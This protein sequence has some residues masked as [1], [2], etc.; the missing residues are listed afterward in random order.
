V[1]VW[2]EYQDTGDSALTQL[3]NGTGY[4]TSMAIPGNNPQKKFKIWRIQIPRALRSVNNALVAGRDRIRNPWCKI[5]LG[6][7]NNA[8]T[9][10]AGN[11]TSANSKK[12]VLQD[13]SVQYYI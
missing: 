3:S 8:N 11:D 1:K 7:L 6:K 4:K 9:G 13:L 12:A 10:N 5:T 2:N